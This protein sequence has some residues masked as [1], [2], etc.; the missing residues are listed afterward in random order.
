MYIREDF[1][2]TQISKWGN[3]LALRLPKSVTQ[4]AQLAE[5]DT[6]TISIKEG[7]IVL[8]PSRPRFSLEELVSRI[9]PGNRHQEADW[10]GR[11]GRETW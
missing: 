10:G 2:T 8:E 9:T 7:S 3:S 6:V 11:V 4:Q 5:G 1:L